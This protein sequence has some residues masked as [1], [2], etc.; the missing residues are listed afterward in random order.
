MSVS[1]QELVRNLKG[2][3]TAGQV[4]VRLNGKHV[5][6]GQITGGEMAWSPEG[7]ALANCYVPSP[8]SNEQPPA[9]PKRAASRRV[10]RPRK[11]PPPDAIPGD[12]EF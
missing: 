8:A 5:V 6:V 7:L 3:V 10:G 4:T 9:T 11:E 12:S 1:W 2:S